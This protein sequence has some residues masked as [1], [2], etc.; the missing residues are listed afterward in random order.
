MTL[1]AHHQDTQAQ[2]HHAWGFADLALLIGSV[3]P[4]LLIAA[5]FVKLLKPVLPSQGLLAMLSQAVLYAGILF[6]LYLV[7]RLRHHLSF[8][9]SLGWRVPFA[10]MWQTALT[11]PVLALALSLLGYALK[12]PPGSQ[13]LEKLIADRASLIAVGIFAVIFGPIFEELVFRGFA[14]PLLIRALGVF[15]GLLA[16]SLPFALLHGPQYNWSWQHVL[17]LTLASFVFG[18]IRHRTGSTAASTLAHSG[19]NLTFFTAL[20]LQRNSL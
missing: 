5:L 12:A 10:G 9:R 8:W 11:G 13:F 6:G 7:L 1:P 17:V 18:L 14:Q 4:S 20:F 19:Y 15:G 16:C 2:D 3:V